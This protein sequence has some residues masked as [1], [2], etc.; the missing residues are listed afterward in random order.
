VSK[1]RTLPAPLTFE[2][3]PRRSLGRARVARAS[4]LRLDGVPRAPPIAV[5]VG[6]GVGVPSSVG[7]GPALL[8]TRARVRS[9]SICAGV[10]DLGSDRG[11]VHC[12]PHPAARKGD[13][14][15]SR[16]QGRS[17]LL[18]GQRPPTMANPRKVAAW[19]RGDVGPS[20]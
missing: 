6:R 17:A 3:E 19:P 15:R 10:Y 13:E 1:S 7:H 8:R 5:V 9:R 16:R 11:C 2:A 18:A 12:L 4:H 14:R 20:G